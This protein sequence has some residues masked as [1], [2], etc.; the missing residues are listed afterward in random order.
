MKFALMVLFAV[1]IVICWDWPVPP[2]CTV[3]CEEPLAE[4]LCP[5]CHVVCPDPGGGN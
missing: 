4:G 1:A 2:G 3:V 5:E